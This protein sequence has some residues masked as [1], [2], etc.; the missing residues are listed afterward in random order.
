MLEAVLKSKGVMGKVAKIAL[1]EFPISM[2]FFL[3]CSLFFSV[4]FLETLSS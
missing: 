1:N 4:S 2:P 3:P